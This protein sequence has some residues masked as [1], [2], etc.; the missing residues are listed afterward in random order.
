MD[1]LVF[2]KELGLSGSPHLQGT[3]CF[4]ARKRKNQVMD[5]LGCQCHCS[6]TKYLLQSIEYCKKDGDW[7]E[8]GKLRPKK[9]QTV[10]P[11]PDYLLL[12]R[13]KLKE[14]ENIN[15]GI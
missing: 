12:I 3:V 15:R 5:I 1:Y 7:F 9:S 10:Q 8:A 2:G 13:E 14:I 4:Q 11:K 6:V